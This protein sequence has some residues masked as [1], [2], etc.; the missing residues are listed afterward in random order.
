M[1]GIEREP[2][3]QDDLASLLG[4]VEERPLLD[5]IARRPGGSSVAEE[6]ARVQGNVYDRSLVA[7]RYLKWTE[8]GE[9]LAELCHEFPSVPMMSETPTSS[10]SVSRAG[11]AEPHEHERISSPQ[12]GAGVV[13]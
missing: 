3:L 6:L 4:N 11:G 9:L 12:P 7:A 2:T 8:S 13:R 10:R 1:D 5:W